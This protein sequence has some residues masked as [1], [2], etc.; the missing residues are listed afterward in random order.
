MT[1]RPMAGLTLAA[2]L[3]AVAGPAAALVYSLDFSVPCNGPVSACGAPA[4][5]TIEFDTLGSVT[6]ANITSFAI[7]VASPT[8]GTVSLTDGDATVSFNDNT[9]TGTPI[10]ET[11]VGRLLFNLDAGDGVTSASTGFG[12]GP[13]PRATFTIADTTDD[14]SVELSAINRTGSFMTGVADDSG[15]TTLGES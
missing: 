4:E 5:F 15:S 1:F 9:V 2:A 13:G 8:I 7:D 3:I 10:V 6:T 11:L 14:A 12:G